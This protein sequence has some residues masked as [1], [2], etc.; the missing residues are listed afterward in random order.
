MAPSVTVLT[1]SVTDDA[2]WMTV[3][4][5]LARRGLGRTSPNPAVGCVL[6]RD[7]RAVG[8]GWTGDG[9]RPH[10]E[11]EALR[12]A[13]QSSHGATAYVSLEPCNHRGQTPP[14]TEALIAAG[15]RRC[16]VAMMDPDT[17]VAGQGVT[18]LRERGVDVTLGVGREAAERFYGAYVRHR[19]EGRPGITLKLATTLDGRI[20]T[21]GGESQ[22]ITGDAARAEAHR[23]R[24]THDAVMVGSGTAVVDNPRLSVR[25]P[26]LESVR[27]VRVVV[28]GRLRLPLTHNLVSGAA[29]HP[30]LLITRPDAPRDRR[31]A[32]EAAGVQVIEA[33]LGE[34]A[35][36]ST[37]GIAQVL[38]EHGLTR[39]LV[40]GGSGLAAGLFSADLVDDVVWFRAPRVIGGDGLGAI[41]SFGLD[42]LA[43]TPSFTLWESRAV[44]TDIMET[45]RRS[46]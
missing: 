3:A 19:R 9:G 26:G 40:E 14:C 2:A 8:R 20:A 5:T 22:W 27:P 44:G 39:V 30:T 29:E 6:V 12:R 1:P 21:R 17:R 35:T 4:L 7:G 15:V 16:V 23:L 11:T 32:Y 43:S 41:G 25:L 24:A 45:Y 34:Q 42:R 28:D 37:R 18:H 10:A 38:G 36:L 33:P 46:I 13:G 31:V